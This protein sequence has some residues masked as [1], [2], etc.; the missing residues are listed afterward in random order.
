MSSRGHIATP[1]ARK[2]RFRVMRRLLDPTRAAEV[3]VRATGLAIA[4]ATLAI[5]ALGLVHAQLFRMP[6]FGLNDEWNVPAWFSGLLLVA[7]GWGAWCAA[8]LAAPD[9]ASR[10][11]LHGLALFL[12]FMGVDEVTQV[13]E[14]VERAAQVHWQFLY[15]PV[16]AVGAVGW[17]LALRWL[18]WHALARACMLAG[19]AAWFAAQVLEY[20]Q[21]ED[22]RLVRRWTIAPEELFEMGGSLLWLLALLLALQGRRDAVSRPQRT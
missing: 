2:G 7:A 22:G 6:A 3:P 8:R 1:D 9:R 5:W 20:V 16:I 4:A 17:T 21:Y 19:A 14:R 11:G 13:H 12:V 18:W 10:L 15:A